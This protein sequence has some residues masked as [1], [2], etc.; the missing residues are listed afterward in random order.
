MKFLELHP[1]RTFA[2]YLANGLL[3]GFRIGFDYDHKSCAPAWRN[4]SSAANN[5]LVISK[6]IKEE[7]ALGHLIPI[8]TDA[9]NSFPAIQLSL[10][11]VIPKRSQP[12]KW[13]LIIDLSSPKGASV[14]DGINQSLTLLHYSSV[15]EAVKVVLMLGTGALMAKLD[16]KVAYRNVP[17]HP[18]D[19]P[20]LGVMWENT[21][22]IDTALPFGLRSA[23]KIF[24]AVADGVLWAMWL[25]GARL[26]LHYLDDF[27]FFGQP[28]S[29]DCARALD[30][31]IGTCAQLG[32]VAHKI[33]RP[34][35][36]PRHRNRCPTPLTG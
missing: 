10:F 8:Q 28:G 17:V 24:S 2:L 23:P 9:L 20:L 35:T 32:F 27:I 29:G 4:M 21:I 33:A 12:N 36:I 7:L 26:L 11:G 5:P 22:F 13:R 31:G 3:S 6:Y 25:N 16:L 18:E 34:A 1:D 19:R 14:N 15:N 30:I